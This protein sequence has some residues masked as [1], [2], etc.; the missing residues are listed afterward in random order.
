MMN[1]PWLSILLLT[2]ILGALLLAL[3]YKGEKDNSFLNYRGV[4]LWV[5]FTSCIYTILLVINFNPELTGFQYIEYYSWAKFI[6]VSYQVGVDGISIPLLLLNQ[7]LTFIV[8]LNS[9]S[10]QKCL[11]RGYY[12]M[13]LLLQAFTTGVLISIDTVTFFIFFEIIC[14]P[15]FF[16]IG[17]WGGKQRLQAALN[18]FVYMF[19]ASIIL[20]IAIL[21][22]KVGFNIHA[23]NHP[24]SFSLKDN[25]LLFWLFF[26]AFAIKIPLV[27]LHSWLPQAHVQAPTGGS[28]ILAGIL[29]KLGAYG[30][31]RFLLK[32]TP[33]LVNYYSQFVNVLCVSTLVYASLLAY[34]QT[35]LKKLIAYSSIAHMTFVVVAFFNPSVNTLKGALILMFAHGLSSAGLFIC[36]GHLLDQ[37]HKRTLS[38]FGGLAHIIPAFSSLFF[39]VTLVAVSFP[40]FPNFLGEILI[41]TCEYKNA[42]WTS[43][44]MIFGT[45]LCATYLLKLFI[46]IVWGE[47]KEEV[48]AEGLKDLN[49]LQIISLSIILIT[50]LFLGL[51]PNVFLSRIEPSLST[52]SINQ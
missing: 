2:P 49:L 13:I 36:A 46:S 14:I 38:E 26:I 10:L 12:I 51:A 1:A 20:L 24:Y 45:L 52:Y 44:A 27:P 7:L 11:S 31:L 40:V 47:K 9:Y 34:R 19:L 29:L 18:Y 41:I 16:L 48:V 5:S 17:L 22:L 23:L 42:P 6:N 4:A 37:T 25:H 50:S 30:M 8:I 28:V 3:M 15:V 32:F 33:D 21:Y 43:F 39:V 35:H